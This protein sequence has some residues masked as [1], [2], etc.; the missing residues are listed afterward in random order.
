MIARIGYRVRQFWHSLFASPLSD[1][2]WQVVCQRLNAQEQ[3]LFRQYS[4][5][6]QW[7]GY[8][9]LR[10]L[11]A[12]GH[13][14]SDLLTAALL[15]D[16]GKSRMPLA[17][18][19]RVLIVLVQAVLPRKA[20]M[21]GRGKVM[22]ATSIVGW[23]RPFIVRAKH[24]AWGAEMAA[25]VGCSPLTVALIRRHQDKLPVAVAMGDMVAMGGAAI[26][27]EDKLLHLLQWADNQN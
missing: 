12:A 15:H 7:H 19:E 25:S 27:Q 21:W 5:S 17:I 20:M 4:I 6:D 10:T 11:Q 8:N 18:W 22:A 23:K 14:Q 13:Q 3:W 24:P 9:V 26:T 1:G 2:D 16:V